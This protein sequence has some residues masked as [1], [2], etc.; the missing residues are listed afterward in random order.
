MRMSDVLTFSWAMIATACAM[1]GLTQCFLWWHSR[2]EKVYP[3]S[4]LMAFSAMT[5]SVLEMS[6]SQ[7][8]YPAEH[9]R[10]LTW[11]NF[12]VALVLVPMVW[13]IQAYL[14]TA[15]R[16]M[17][18]LI[19]A[20]WV[21]GM[22]VNFLL[23]GNLTFSE[24]V[25]VD[26]HVTT[27]GDA[28][29]LARGN[30]N[31]WKWL[32]DITVLMIPIYTIDAAWRA[33]ENPRARQGRVIAVGVGLFVLIAGLQ[34]ILIDLGH[35][36]APFAISPAFLFVIVALTWALAKDAVRANK[37]DAQIVEAR[38]E[39]ERLMRANLMGEVAATL[40]H[41]INQP[42]TAILGNA[43]AAEKFLNHPNPNLDEIREIFADIVRDDKRARDIIANLRRMLRGDRPEDR[44]VDLAP[45]LRE[46]LLFMHHELQRQSIDVQLD[47]NGA[48]PE[49]CGGRV[50]IQQVVMNLVLNAA[51][52]I[53][54]AN[55]SRREIR[56]R[57]L[58]K[59]GGAEIV[60]RDFGPGIANEVEKR[61]FEPFVTTKERSLGMGLAV[62]QRIVENEGGQITVENAGGGG[63]RFRVWLPACQL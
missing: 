59:Q 38:R 6:L 20:L 42:L 49:V 24:V 31:D 21:V 39:T 51:R 8:P 62:C 14:P 29:F 27:W 50:A 17:A 37:L 4:M 3:L 11:L 44:R 45:A 23:P 25:A 12:T 7:T 19:T 33:R 2:R 15:R 47:V 13:S 52:A 5:V 35:Y 22:A 53:L 34:A 63:A 61:L 55:A 41:E 60:V 16:W 28:Y 1:L 36:Q 56:I 58:E 30:I 32:V 18:I 54:D 57:V 26:R 10:L 43:Q 48:I 9:E 46:V 40:A